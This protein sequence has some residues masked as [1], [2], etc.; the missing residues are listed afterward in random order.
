[1][2]KAILPG[3]TVTQGDTIRYQPSASNPAYQESIYQVVKTEQHYFEVVVKSDKEEP[4]EHSER[5]K[6]KT[7]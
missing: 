7:K 2:W 4:G 5:K 1:M 6:L 3:E